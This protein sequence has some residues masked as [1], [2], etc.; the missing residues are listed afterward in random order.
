MSDPKPLLMVGG[1]ADGRWLSATG[2]T[3]H[4]PSMTQASFGHDTEFP[5]STIHTYRRF[6]MAIMEVL[7]HESLQQAD[8]YKMA[9]SIVDK[10]LNNYK[11]MHIEQY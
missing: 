10:I 1:P 7:V 9:E 2:H 3:V 8:S 11:V 4:V 5:G 6:R